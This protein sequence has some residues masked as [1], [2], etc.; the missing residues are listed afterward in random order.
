M[1]GEREISHSSIIV[2]ISMATNNG[3]KN[4]PSEGGYQEYLE[5]AYIHSWIYP[6]IAICMPQG[7]FQTGSKVKINIIV[8][9]F[10]F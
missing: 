8:Y 1:G 3:T 9:I 4:S 2:I 7:A 5:S 6:G 10:I